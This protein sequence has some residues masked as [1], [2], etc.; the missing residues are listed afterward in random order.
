MSFLGSVGK[1]LSRK[2]IEKARGKLASRGA[3]PTC[4]KCGK[5]SAPV[6]KKGDFDATCGG[7]RCHKWVQDGIR[8]SD[9]VVLRKIGF[10]ADDL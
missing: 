9:P 3:R 10:D 6:G 1:N 5:P 2:A 4:I 7:G 8:R